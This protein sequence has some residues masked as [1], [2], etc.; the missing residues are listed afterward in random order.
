M[1]LI[2]LLILKPEN[3]E[4][5]KKKNFEEKKRQKGKRESKE[6]ETVEGLG[7]TPHIVRLQ[8]QE[9]QPTTSLII[10]LERWELR[11]GPPSL[12]IKSLIWIL[13]V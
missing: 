12:P 4:E 1:V 9:D 2:L 13:T 3:S 5:T 10:L 6:A 7:L 8:V 11:T